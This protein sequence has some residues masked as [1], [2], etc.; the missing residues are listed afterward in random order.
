MQPIQSGNPVGVLARSS[1]ATAID[2]Y[3]LK[4][5]RNAARAIERKIQDDSPEIAPR[6]QWEFVVEKAQ[7]LL[8]NH[9][10]DLEIA[11]WLTEG[12]LRTQG[13]LGLAQGFLVIKTLVDNFGSALYP[14]PDEDGVETTLKALEGL[15]GIDNDGSLIRPIREQLITQGRSCGPYAYWQYQQALA[16]NQIKDPEIIKKRLAAGAISQQQIELAV[17]E[18]ADSFYQKL[19]NEINQAQIAFDALQQSL[20]KQYADKAPPYSRI[21]NVLIEF[22]EHLS[23][24]KPQSSVITD[25]TDSNKSASREVSLSINIDGLSDRQQALQQL[26]KVAYYFRNAEPHSPLSYAIERII[27]WGSLSLPD[28]MRELINDENARKSF[29]HLTG[30]PY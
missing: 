2:Y 14:L 6:Q 22:V 17:Q 20:A 23:F 4:D 12:L 18:T 3:A 30:I 21:K 13:F 25:V 27:R 1:E 7:D 19:H 24:L 10:K 15:N 29:I 5:A 28:L 8:C 11:A 26:T 16:I 9:T